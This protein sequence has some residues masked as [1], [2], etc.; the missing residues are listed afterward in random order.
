[1]GKVMRVPG[2]H[3]SR[4]ATGRNTGVLNFCAERGKEGVKQ[5][6]NSNEGSPAN[7]FGVGWAVCPQEKKSSARG[8]IAEKIAAQGERTTDIYRWPGKEASRETETG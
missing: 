6:F 7:S 3:P 5:I 4:M 1:M 2:K 8:G